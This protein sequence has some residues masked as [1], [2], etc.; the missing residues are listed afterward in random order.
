MIGLPLQPVALFA[1]GADG[2][3]MIVTTSVDDVPVQFAFDPKTETVEVLIVFGK[4][5]TA[6]SV[7]CPEETTAPPVADQV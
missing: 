7:P 5:I 2:V 6:D 4:T 3:V 1:V